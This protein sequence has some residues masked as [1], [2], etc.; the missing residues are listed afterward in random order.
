M[1]RSLRDLPGPRPLPLIG[2][3]IAVHRAHLQFE[4]WAR[5]Y[6]R[7]FKFHVGP[8]TIVGVT[9]PEIA[10]AA[11]QQR[12][13][14]YTRIQR[15]N[16]VMYE[17]HVGGVFASEGEAWRRQRRLINPSFHARHLDTFEDDAPDTCTRWD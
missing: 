17:L 3:P 6:G 4:S 13:D 15:T 10:R 9:D 14:R 11:L 5:R 12:P 16:D 1:S 8:N 7:M 2:N